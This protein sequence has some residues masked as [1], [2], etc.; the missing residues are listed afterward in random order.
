MLANNVFYFLK[1]YVQDR[2]TGDNRVRDSADAEIT[3]Q[4]VS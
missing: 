3:K 4:N 2:K 1:V